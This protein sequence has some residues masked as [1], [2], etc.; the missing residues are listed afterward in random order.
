MLH[1]GSP[2]PASGPPVVVFD[3]VACGYARDPVLSGMDLE[4]M[5]GDF[6][7]FLGPSG[8]G[9]STLLRLILGA[10]RLFSGTVLIDGVPLGRRRPNVGYVPQLETINW[11]F[12][13]TV[14]ETVLMGAAMRKP[15]L[16]W[17]SPR[18]R[19]NALEI[20]ERLG[21]AHLADR[22]IRQLSGGEQ[23]RAFLA[24]ALISNPGLLLL[25]EPVAGVDIKTRDEVMHLL[26]ELNHQGVTIVMTTHQINSVAAHLPRVVCINGGIVAQG[27]PADVFTTDI[28]RRT[29][30]ADIPVIQYQG[31]TLV[32]ER[33]HAYGATG[34]EHTMKEPH[35]PD[36]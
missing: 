8:S 18:Q 26:H 2:P 17:H 35:L 28:L 10:V 19:T 14:R 4:I 1:P 21:I 12:P 32:A 9:K 24:R 16:P 27:P 22:Q 20:M 23:Q 33:P 15:F 25:D 5:P 11:N 13:V 3:N 36:V 34:E 31:L 6:V 30:G 29:Y 7:G